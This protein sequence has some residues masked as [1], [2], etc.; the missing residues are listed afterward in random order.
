MAQRLPEDVLFSPLPENVPSFLNEDHH[1]GD[2]LW[3]LTQLVDCCSGSLFVWSGD[4]EATRIRGAKAAKLATL[5]WAG[6]MIE[7][8]LPVESFRAA[9]TDEGNIEALGVRLGI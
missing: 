2:G 6:V 9:T 3:K 7:M 8:E 4:A 1:K 5:P